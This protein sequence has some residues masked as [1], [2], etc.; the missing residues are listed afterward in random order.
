MA[1]P[2]TVTLASGFRLTQGWGSV[3]TILVGLI[4]VAVAS[5]WNFRTLRRTEERYRD[6]LNEAHLERM[7]EAVVEVA[8]RTTMWAYTVVEHRAQVRRTFLPGSGMPKTQSEATEAEFRIR[9]AHW[10]QNNAQADLRR[11]LWLAQLVVDNPELHRVILDTIAIQEELKAIDFPKWD[12]SLMESVD[13]VQEVRVRTNE[14]V[15]KLLAYATCN[16]ARHNPTPL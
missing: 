2:I 7:R 15:D 6:D 1:Y 11:A 16:L 3:G 13:A 9:E 5:Y 12:A 8:H 4:A 14:R 10:A